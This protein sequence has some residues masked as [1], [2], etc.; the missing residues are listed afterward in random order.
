MPSEYRPVNVLPLRVIDRAPVDTPLHTEQNYRRAPA[1]CGQR[2]LIV[3]DRQIARR[4]LF[5]CHPQSKGN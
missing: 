2:E 3:G 5:G 1:A 4:P